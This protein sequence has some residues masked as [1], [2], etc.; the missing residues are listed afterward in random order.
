V[1][2]HER[3]TLQVNSNHT[4]KVVRETVARLFKISDFDLKHNGE[5]LLARE[6]DHM[7]LG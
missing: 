2:S 3:K 5:K 4:I 6:N 7:V 1:E